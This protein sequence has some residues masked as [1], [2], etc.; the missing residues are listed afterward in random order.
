MVLRLGRLGDMAEVMR[1][2][3]THARSRSVAEL[4]EHLGT[5]V[6]GRGG[7]VEVTG[8][9]LNTSHVA[10]GDLYAAL[11]G[12]RSHGIDHL[13][14]AVRAGAVAVLTDPVGAS[15][16]LPVPAV[17][18]DHP[19]GRLAE[20]SAWFYEHPSDAFTTFGVTGTQGKT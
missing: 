18:V 9:S 7:D 6:P 14:K 5:P 1:I 8:L 11:A 16:P 17:V 12:A 19:R 3:P 2:R 10:P 20:L 15:D 13:D 4:A